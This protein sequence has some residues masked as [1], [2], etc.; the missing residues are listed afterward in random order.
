MFIRPLTPSEFPLLQSFL[1]EA[2]FV[3]PGADPP[4]YEIIYRPELKLYYEDFGTGP[5]DRCLVAEVDG[6][7]VGAVWTRIMR[8]Y[9]HVDDETPSLAIA[10]YKEYRGQGIGTKLM[11]EMLALL[12][13]EG[14]RQVSLSVQKAN[15]AVR[16]YQKVGFEI[17]SENDEEYIMICRLQECVQ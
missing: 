17:T 7:V 14:F 9:G 13:A 3:P 8:D 12:K 1:Y 6:K 11:Q 5:A 10:L 4:P 15:Y 2:I 16:M